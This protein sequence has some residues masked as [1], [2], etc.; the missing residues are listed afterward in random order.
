MKKCCF[1]GHRTIKNIDSVKQKLFVVIENLIVNDNV[2]T[3]LFGSKSDFDYICHLIVTE[4]KEKYAN[5]K[6]I[7]YTCKS[8]SCVIESERKKWEKIHSYIEK[9]DVHL[10]GVEEEYEHRTKYVAGKASYIERN[11]A[12]INDSD[13]CVFYY[14]PTYLPSRRKF[15][16]K[17]IGDYQP[18]SGTKLAFEYANKKN[19]TIINIKDLI[20]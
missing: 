6:R 2:D 20:N 3:F 15:S 16:K 17:N 1:I 9:R 18:N 4:L 8:E 13:F 5:I 19:K 11:Q 10:L 14:D 12:L 7:A